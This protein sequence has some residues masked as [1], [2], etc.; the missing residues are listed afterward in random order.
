[1]ERNTVSLIG[2]STVVTGDVIHGTFTI[3]RAFRVPPSQVFAAFASV[4]AKNVWGDTG[5]LETSV[6][7]E[8]PVFDFRVGGHETFDVVMEGVTFRYDARYY[9]IVVDRR[10][11]YAY[12]MYAD[13]TRISVS[14][15]TIDFAPKDAGTVLT[16]TEQGVFLD[17]FDGGDAPRLRGDGTT[18]MLDNL[19]DFLAPEAS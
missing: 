5:N 1:M 7:A 17:G 3:E 18:E 12:E 14:L 19:V 9:D 4:E 11:V 10:L 13:G 16:Y 2:G 8:Q 6:G 15:T